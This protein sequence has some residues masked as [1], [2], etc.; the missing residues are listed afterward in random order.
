[1]P[2]IEE[3]RG[4]GF[5]VRGEKNGAKFELGRFATRVE[6]ESFLLD[7]Y[8]Q[9]SLPKRKAARAAIV[10][11]DGIAYIPLTGDDVAQVDAADLP[12]VQ[13]RCWQIRHKPNERKYAHAKGVGFMHRLILGNPLG[14]IDHIDRDGL[15][16]CRSNLRIATNAENGW[17]RGRQRNNKSGFKGVHLHK[18]RWRATIM[19]NGVKHDLGYFDDPAVAAEAYRRAAGR[20]HGQFA[21][22]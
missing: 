21:S 9:V 6:A 14:S 16:N 15:N 3:R 13:G 11:V 12:L 19:A 1:M 20:L 22:S 4:V 8:G 5:R 17:N 18:G 10:V 7:E 2:W